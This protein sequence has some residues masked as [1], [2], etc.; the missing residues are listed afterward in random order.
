MIVKLQESGQI[1][2]NK[3]DLLEINENENEKKYQ[4]KYNY[5]KSRLLDLYNFKK[6]CRY[7][8][9]NPLNAKIINKIHKFF[10]E[11]KNI[12]LYCYCESFHVTYHLEK[13]NIYSYINILSKD[14]LIN[15]LN[16]DLDINDLINMLKCESIVS[17]FWNYNCEDYI[18]HFVFLDHDKV[19][20]FK[21]NNIKPIS[22]LEINDITNINHENLYLIN[23]VRNTKEELILIYP[24]KNINN[25]I[26][27]KTDKLNKKDKLITYNLIELDVNKFNLTLL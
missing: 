22:N 27:F 18:N 25:F 1:L 12:I 3:H 17:L 6:A 13:R 21:L 24:I 5:V 2:I 10:T 20:K 14:E 19:K 4:K 26:H 9:K 8:G 7:N 15:D 23:N 11:N 16:T